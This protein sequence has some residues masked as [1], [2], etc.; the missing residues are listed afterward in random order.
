MA[1]KF[2]DCNSVLIENLKDSRKIKNTKLSTSNWLRVWQ[3]WAK[4]KGHGTTK[5]L[6]RTYQENLTKSSN[7]F[8]R[9]YV[10]KTDYKPDSLSVM[11]IA[12]DRHL[13]EEGYKQSIVS[14]KVWR[15]KTSPQ[16]EIKAPPTRR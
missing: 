15:L 10:N 14:Q 13:K 12:I 4:E 16:R 8:T 1:G 2:G 3:T 11:A 5:T 7:N 6:S 9:R